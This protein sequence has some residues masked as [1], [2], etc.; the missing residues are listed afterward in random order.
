MNKKIS[1]F[2]IIVLIALLFTACAKDT[3]SFEEKL[4]KA[5]DYT[6]GE[7]V[8][9]LSAIELFREVIKSKE[10]NPHHTSSLS[11]FICAT[12][13]LENN[14]SEVYE[15]YQTNTSYYKQT[16]TQGSGIV[17]SKNSG[18][19][20]FYSDGS[21]YYS[22]ENKKSQT[23]DLEAKTFDG[24][25]TK[26]NNFSDVAFYIDY[27]EF[28][29]YKFDDEYLSADH[30]DSVYKLNDKYYFTIT[31]KTK[32]NEGAQSDTEAVIIDNIGTSPESFL[33]TQDTTITC[34]VSKINGEY[35]LTAR[36]MS[37]YYSGKLSGLNGVCTNVT[38]AT[39][40]YS[41][42]EIPSNLITLG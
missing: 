1:F 6:Q 3:S 12:S 31:L 17:A 18:Y 16:I 39:Y 5:P 22:Y 28:S 27:I 42:I 26:L 32:D 25:M 4:W 40:D 23:V 7:L 15:A 30:I 36:R 34:E 2:V 33:W 13:G 24:N 11:L 38:A 20:K 8:S 37:E 35:R 21:N 29:S 14:Q 10:T 41:I 19:K 9:S